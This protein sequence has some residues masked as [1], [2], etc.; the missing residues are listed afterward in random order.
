M[1]SLESLGRAMEESDAAAEYRTRRLTQPD[2]RV[3]ATRNVAAE[4]AIE[5]S[6]AYRSYLERRGLAD[7]ESA[8]RDFEAAYARGS[9][10]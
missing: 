4:A 10:Y 2:P 5:K 8:R 9:I 3:P 7:D 6:K 1:R